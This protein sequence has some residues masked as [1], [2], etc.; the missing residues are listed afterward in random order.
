[1]KLLKSTN[2]QSDKMYVYTYSIIFKY[3]KLFTFS[4]N[5]LLGSMKEKTNHS[6]NILHQCLY[7]I[8]YHHTYTNDSSRNII[9]IKF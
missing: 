4:D 9:K 5:I 8:Y 1:M 7:S 3:T 2:S 6:L